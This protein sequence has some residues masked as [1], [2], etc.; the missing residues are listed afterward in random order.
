MK[1]TVKYFL[2][3]EKLIGK[4]IDEFEFSN[5]KSLKEILEKN[6]DKEKMEKLKDLTLIITKNGENCKDLNVEIENNNVFCLCP[7]IYGG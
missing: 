3:I 4:N 6:I 5:E 1:I 7:A 2:N